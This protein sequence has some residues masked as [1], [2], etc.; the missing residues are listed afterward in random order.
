MSDIISLIGTSTAWFTPLAAVRVYE[1]AY[2]LSY[3][4]VNTACLS[5]TLLFI[6]VLCL[7]YTILPYPRT[8][9]IVASIASMIGL[10][11]FVIAPEI[12]KSLDP[13]A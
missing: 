12:V 3:T 5:M 13:L 6:P 9:G 1:N 4:G 8:I 7:F 10:T 2:A 11:A